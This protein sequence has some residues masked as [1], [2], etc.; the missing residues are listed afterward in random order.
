VSQPSNWVSNPIS[1]SEVG[2][3]AP[4]GVGERYSTSSMRRI[5]HVTGNGGSRVVR[6]RTF[7]I[8]SDF[9]WSR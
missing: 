9:D 6:G 3:D 2:R 8:G 1:V 5:T 7:V 4:A